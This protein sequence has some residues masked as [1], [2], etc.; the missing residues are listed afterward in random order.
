MGKWNTPADLKYS[1]SD[2]WLRIDGDT[3][4]VG[5]TDYAQDQLNDVVFLELPEVGAAFGADS[6]FGVV[7]SVKAAS[8]LHLPVSGT[9]T[10]V[11]HAAEDEPETVNTAPYDA[12]WLVKIKLN[13]PAEADS[14]MD[15]DAYT[16]YCEDR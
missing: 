16:T 13:N 5:I 12:G 7:E 11:N 9:I 4:T 10:E 3:A 1:K 6:V 8:D 14:L 2:E 15:A